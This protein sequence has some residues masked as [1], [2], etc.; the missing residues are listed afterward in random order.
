MKLDVCVFAHL[1]RGPCNVTA[2]CLLSCNPQVIGFFSQ[3]LEQ[4]GSDLSV[5]RVQE[6]IMKGAQALPKDRL[7][8]GNTHAG[9]IEL[10]NME[11]EKKKQKQSWLKKWKWCNIQC[12]T[13]WHY[14]LLEAG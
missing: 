7:K 9:W 2:G 8:V 3:R 5:E 6:V 14:M 12:V 11:E 1:E 10:E 13:V 4:A